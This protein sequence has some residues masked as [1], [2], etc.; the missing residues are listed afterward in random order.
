MPNYTRTLKRL[1]KIFL[2]T[3]ILLLLIFF[4]TTVYL[5]HS[6]SQILTADKFKQICDDIYSSPTLP[7]HFKDTYTKVYPN[8][9]DDNFNTTF[10][11][12]IL[13]KGQEQ[14]P[15]RQVANQCWTLFTGTSS[16]F[17]QK[18]NYAGFVWLLE[19]NVSQEKCFEYFVS[20]T[21]FLY[22]TK[23]P[24]QAAQFYYKKTLS[25]LTIDEEIGLILKIKNP[26]FYDNI[27]FPDR[28][29][30]D[31]KKLKDKITGHNSG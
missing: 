15:S 2:T 22:N 25:S 23:G 18:L 31:I 8:A 12:S 9:F 27:R 13:G 10:V 4:G 29:N 19:D 3:V 21:D 7:Q 16:H 24:E 11:K 17:M 1:F 28:C 14:C 5:K 30:K 6:A 20:R 26:S